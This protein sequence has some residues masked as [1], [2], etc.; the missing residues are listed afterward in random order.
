[1][2]EGVH[3][4]EIQCPLKLQGIRK[5]PSLLCLLCA[6]FGVTT[7]GENPVSL[8][9]TFH[10]TT[11]RVVGVELNIHTLEMRFF[12]QSRYCKKQKIKKLV[13][14]EKPAENLEWFAL[15]EFKE[16]GNTVTLNP[17]RSRPVP[18]TTSAQALSKLPE[19]LNFDPAHAKIALLEQLV[20]NHII[21]SST[22]PKADKYDL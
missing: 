11:E 10:S 2:T 15:V 5:S 1:M 22:H 7:K 19:T 6:E 17:F 21:V 3:Y 4:W 9:Q 20:G 14:L 18:E 8:T 13:H 16:S 12:I